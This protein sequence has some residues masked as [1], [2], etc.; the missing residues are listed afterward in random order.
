MCCG[1]LLAMQQK[2]G[3]MSAIAANPHHSEAIGEAALAVVK[4]AIHM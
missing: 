2:R 1:S 3:K 4:R